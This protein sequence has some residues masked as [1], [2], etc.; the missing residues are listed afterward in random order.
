M[1]KILEH[2]DP[3]QGDA[4]GSEDYFIC[5][6]DVLHCMPM[7]FGS[8]TTMAVCCLLVSVAKGIWTDEHVAEHAPWQGEGSLLEDN[9]SVP[10]MLVHEVPAKG[11]M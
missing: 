3:V 2:P 6:A 11:F 1:A 5:S 9:E 7:A 8:S 10:G 4:S